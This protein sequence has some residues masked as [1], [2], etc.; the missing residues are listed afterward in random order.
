VGAQQYRDA[1]FLF[2]SACRILAGKVAL[3]D[4]RST[5]EDIWQWSKRKVDELNTDVLDFEPPK[6]EPEEPPP[7]VEYINDIQVAKFR[8][9]C[10]KL[11]MTEGGIKLFLEDQ[12]YAAIT[13]IP[14]D[15]FEA[16]WYLVR[17]PDP[18]VRYRS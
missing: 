10:L 8:E 15:K 11:G 18:T 6:Q 3:K 7:Q 16:I 9:R 17:S 14:V 4:W 13:A 12:G 2:G 5:V 1:Y